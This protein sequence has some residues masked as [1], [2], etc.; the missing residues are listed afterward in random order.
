MNGDKKKKRVQFDFS[1]LEKFGED[2]Q[3]PSK[4]P[5]KSPI[6]FD[7]SDM[8]RVQ[9]TTADIDVTEIVNQQYGPEQM[10]GASTF[11]DRV[12]RE[13]VVETLL[14]PFKTIA[15]AQK[16]IPGAP[17]ASGIKT[18]TGTLT[19]LGELV[20]LPFSQAD[21]LARKLPGGDVAADI[22]VLPF[23]ATGDLVQ[24]H[25]LDP[26]KTIIESIQL[27]EDQR[28]ATMEAYRNIEGF[29]HLVTQF[30]TGAKIFGGKHGKGKEKVAKSPDKIVDVRETP[31]LTE[32]QESIKQAPEGLRTA[33]D[34]VLNER[35]R[36]L[37]LDPEL[38]TT[39]ASKR[40]G[41]RDA[42]ALQKISGPEEQA[43]TAEPLRTV[44]GEAAPVELPPSFRKQ[45]VEELGPETMTPMGKVSK[46]YDPDLA[47]VYEQSQVQIKPIEISKAP[48]PPESYQ[49]KNT[50]EAVSL[51]E[52]LTPE[53]VRAV[54]DEYK[55]VES[56][57]LETK[58][59]KTGYRA[60]LLKEQV[61]GFIAKQEGRPHE[62][63]RPQRI[64][65]ILAGTDRE[66]KGVA[67]RAE[68]PLEIPNQLIEMENTLARTV[69][70][71]I[72]EKVAPGGLSIQEVK[73]R[74]TVT[75]K[76]DV[77]FPTEIET[78][79]EKAH[80]IP[81]PNFFEKLKQGIETARNRMTREFEHLPHT[82]EFAELRFG[83]NKLQKQKNV[84]A[85]RVIRAIQGITVKLNR[86]NFSLF[87]RK[88][89]LDD[90][91]GEVAAG[92]NLPFGF[93]PESLNVAKKKIDAQLEKF[94]EVKEAVEKRRQFS[95]AARAEYVKSLKEAAFDVAEKMKNDDYYRHQVL[96]YANA[97]GSSGA[98]KKLR[99][100]TG[101]GFLKER[102]GSTY[103]INT[104]YLQ[105]EYSV[106][107]QMLHDAEVAKTISL[108]KEKYDIYS[109]VKADA[110]AKGISVEQAIPEG[111]AEWQSREGNVFYFSDSIPA[112]LAENLREGILKEIGVTAEDLRTVLAVGQKRKPMIVKE[113]I[114]KTLDNLKTTR[115]ES[116]L[117]DIDK[118]ILG[119]WKEWQLISP[120]RWFRYNFRNITGDGDAVTVGNPSAFKLAPQATKE[121]YQTMVADRGMTPELREWFRRGGFETTLQAQELWQLDKLKVFDNITN[122][123]KSI[124]QIPGRAFK[125]YWNSARVSTNL[126]ESV[127][128]YAAYLDYL[129]QIKKSPEGKPNNYGGSIREEID[130][131]KDP[132]DKAF[133]L[134]ND[135]LGAYD[136]V[137][138]G[139]QWLRR[140]AYPF[141]SWKEVNMKRYYRFARNAFQDGKGMEFLGKKAVGTLAKSPITALRV[142][143]FLAKATAFWTT[144]QAWNHLMYPELEN[145]LPKDIQSRPH[146]VFGS[147]DDGNPV[148]F[149]RMGALGDILEWFG[150]DDFP[151]EFSLWMQGKK[152][153]KEV[154]VDMAKS[155]VNV[156][157]QGLSPLL[158]MP[159]EIVSGK[160]LFPDAF[161]PRTIR[162]TG[163]YLADGIGLGAEY[164]AL[165]GLPAKPYN[166]SMKDFF[167]YTVDSGQSAYRDV[168]E[169]KNR[170]FKKIEKESYGSFISPKSNALYNY[171]LALRYDDEDTATKFLTQYFDMGGTKQGLT[172]G[173]EALSPFS[174]LSKK[175]QREFVRSLDEEERKRAAQAL[176]FYQNVL[177]RSTSNVENERMRKIEQ[178]AIRRAFGKSKRITAQIE[179]EMFKSMSRSEQIEV[180]K[181]MEPAKR[182]RLRGLVNSQ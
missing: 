125:A 110:E 182:E 120:R 5:V 53:Q 113:E 143:K 99:M 18:A 102:K 31:K 128:R 43:R 70:E 146:I 30:L 136:Q 179:D 144:L 46:L 126:R 24:K 137:S 118:R 6:S 29:T 21:V 85:D 141:W 131:L 164:R 84:A 10:Q 166:E 68:R 142:G 59:Y 45:I 86:D 3:E 169:M 83:L 90:L 37:G 74:P 97:Q 104:N 93:T 16:P 158:K 87:E 65:Q 56:E 151:N 152:T 44:E 95:H 177:L 127:L 7:F 167:F 54:W 76:P 124:A 156:I 22:A 40:Q 2:G 145:Q 67:Q 14:H 155:P 130:A 57:A 88:V 154:A 149:T 69:D 63:L 47:K 172:S 39:E 80:G 71:M 49:V 181:D 1:D 138:V 161:R 77:S 35:L 98:G 17:I 12:K 157:V 27:P 51:G 58:D 13:P 170:F 107:T 50:P 117:A 55:K 100:P 19:G 139:G 81:H 178:T 82:G 11:W 129:E 162:D 115:E 123:D 135:L 119:A 133:Q 91:A 41:I 109:K 89:I 62:A 92:R 8:P 160:Q 174:G 116:V 33:G 147:D 60:Q 122:P 38:Y 64:D 132:R 9:E 32:V 108:V 61:E 111:Y 25:G 75:E 105:A 96:M 180:L 159:A 163:T 42:E 106:L 48:V 121:L 103:D 140:Y 101:R 36:E 26:I 175:E 72:P 134:S 148:V 165:M 28:S 73:S 4:K 150:L 23:T 168:Y 20:A 78:R 94:P 52:K 153:L 79:F 114:A 34:V 112:K 15:E 171:R 176:N 66:L 173:I